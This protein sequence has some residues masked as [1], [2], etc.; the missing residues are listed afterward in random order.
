MILR[1]AFCILHLQI[2]Y[3]KSHLICKPADETEADI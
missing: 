1:L 3:L 2:K